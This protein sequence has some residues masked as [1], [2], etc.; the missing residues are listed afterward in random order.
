M[1]R[2][3]LFS[4]AVGDS[5]GGGERVGAYDAIELIRFL[6]KLHALLI[7]CWHL[8]IMRLCVNARTAGIHSPLSLFRNYS[9][10]SQLLCTDP[11]FC[12]FPESRPPDR[13]QTGGPLAEARRIQFD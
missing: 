11:C 7:S 9:E 1:A 5:L 12:V 2:R 3:R 13:G 10:I 8:I 6:G 4:L